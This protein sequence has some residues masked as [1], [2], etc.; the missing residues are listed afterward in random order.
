VETHLNPAKF[1][2]IHRSY[3]VNLDRIQKLQQWFHGEYRVVLHDTR[4]GIASRQ[5]QLKKSPPGS[6]GHF[7]IF[8]SVGK[9]GSEIVFG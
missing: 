7:V 5:F 3:I 9:S 8:A 2:R 4:T 6:L 1:A